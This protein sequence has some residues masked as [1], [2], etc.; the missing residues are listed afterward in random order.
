MTE[1]RDDTADDGGRD[2]ENNRE[3]EHRRVET[4]LVQPGKADAAPEIRSRQRRPKPL[5]KPDA[6]EG[7]PRAH[8]PA[9]HREDEALGEQMADQPDTTGAERD[10]NRHVVAASRGARQHQVRHVDAGDEQDNADRH[11]HREQRGPH[12]RD[13]LVVDIDELEPPGNGC[14]RLRDVRRF[15]AKSEEHCCGIGGGRRQRHAGGEARRDH[16]DA[17]VAAATD[18]E[19][20]PELGL[21]IGIA[22][23][24]RHDTDDG[25]RLRFGAR[26]DAVQG[27]DAPD[28]I[29]VAAEVSRPQRL[30]QDDDAGLIRAEETPDD[31]LSA[32]H[33]KGV[34]R[35]GVGLSSSRLAVTGQRHEGPRPARDM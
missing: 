4:N 22:K 25:V 12:R 5:Q 31:R 7:E 19:R 35:N 18:V 28:H 3:R 9:G 33:R 24:G 27:D 1:R 32:E 23:C 26:D 30:T 6:A 34:R 13:Q 2:R 16:D 15:A 17:G 14:L 21:R 8:D 11:H 10:A 20:R 29:R